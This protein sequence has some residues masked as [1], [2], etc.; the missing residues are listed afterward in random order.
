ML[1]DWMMTRPDR[2]AR[3]G[4]HLTDP[5]TSMENTKL[6]EDDS[7]LLEVESE[8]VPVIRYWGATEQLR[9]SR[10]W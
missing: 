6:I 1:F 5:V 9:Q 4:D 2:F 10:P 3:T 7:E 8:L